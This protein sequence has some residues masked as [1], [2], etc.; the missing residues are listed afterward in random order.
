MRILPLAAVLL[1]VAPA[2]AQAALLASC[3]VLP[4]L[5][6]FPAYDLSRP[7]PTDSQAQLGINCVALGGLPGSVVYQLSIS[8]S[9]QSGSFN[10]QLGFGAHRLNYNLYTDAARSQVWGDGSAGTARVGGSMAFVLLG[11]N[12]GAS[13]TVYAR[14]PAGQAVTGGMYADRVTLTVEF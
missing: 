4:A 5:L 9:S 3:S 7:A 12:V 6:A 14:L 10:R 2:A 11:L 13:H 1:G 8:R